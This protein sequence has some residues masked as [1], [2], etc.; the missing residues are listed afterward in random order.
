[1]E[2]FLYN[3]V[4]ADRLFLSRIEGYISLLP[5]SHC[6]FYMGIKSL[7]FISTEATSASLIDFLR[8]LNLFLFLILKIVYAFILY[9]SFEM[10]LREC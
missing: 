5:V 7:I 3:G 2:S 4:S 1:M 10:R 8:F 6:L 9:S